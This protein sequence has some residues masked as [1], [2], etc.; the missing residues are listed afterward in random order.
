M[1]MVYLG[2]VVVGVLGLLLRRSHSLRLLDWRCR[3]ANVVEGNADGPEHGG[4]RRSA[5]NRGNDPGA[6]CGE[7]RT[8]L[9]ARF[10]ALDIL[11]AIA[12]I[13]LLGYAFIN[14]MDATISNMLSG[15]FGVLFGRST[16]KNGK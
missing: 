6:N 3:M 5:G 9:G 11:G 2:G 14:G 16:K 10:E 4:V 1:E 15:L 13:G 12:L 7:P 8:S